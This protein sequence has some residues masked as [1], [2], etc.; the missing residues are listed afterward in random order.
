MT[1][2]V[3]EAITSRRSVRAF[4]PTP[5]PRQTV[6]ALLTVASRAAS[7]TNIQPWQVHVVTGESKARLSAAIL[8]VFND[9]A[10]LAKHQSEFSIYPDEW[11]SPY[12]DRRRKVGWDL[13]GLLGI[14]KGD[15][16]R[17]HAQHARNFLFFDAPV[18]L[19]FTLHR[20]LGYAA[21]V[22]YGMFMGNLMTAA[23]ARGLH[24]CP[25]FAFAQ[26]QR[27]IAEVLP[28]PAHERVLCGM[29]L[30]YEDT[31]AVENTLRS[32]R[33]PLAEW[34]TFHA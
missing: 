13:Y 14:G 27:V 16:E 10:R 5:V 2:A 18:G 21:W 7:G 20:S 19:I 33:A 23:R 17:T 22:D 4:L 25:Q 1:S 24:T 32:E 8:D 15:R 31:G 30:G 11:I 26:F 28:L 12:I 29:S 9:P 3:D 6:E 34:T